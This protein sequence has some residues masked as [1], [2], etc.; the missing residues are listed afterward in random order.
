VSLP[1]GRIDPQDPTP[2]AAALRETREELGIDTDG[3]EVHGPLDPVFTVASNYVLLPFVAFTAQTPRF[4]PHD[5]EVAAVIEMPF[6]HLL[7]PETV[8]EE[9]WPLR[10]STYR[11]GL[12]RYGQHRIW[13]AT[14]RV[15]REILDLAGGP[16]PP[17]DLVPPGEVAEARNL[18]PAR[19][20]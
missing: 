8:E 20:R 18:R 14:A 5:Y 4:V 6:R 12:Y 17:P 19:P 15:L 10:G 9:L 3:L 1:G 16:A 2:Q 11:V 13:G 7:R